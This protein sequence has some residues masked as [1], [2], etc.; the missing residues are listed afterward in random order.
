MSAEYASPPAWPGGAH[1]L[2][3]FC[4]AALA[5]LAAVPFLLGGYALHLAVSGGLMAVAAMALTVISGAAGL[6][7]L[8]TAAFLA[9]GAFTSGIMATQFGFGLGPSLFVSAA[10]G[11]F[12]GVLVAALTLRASGLYLA[13]G[14]LALQNVVHVVATD[15][16]LKLTFAAGFSL[17]DPDLLGLKI[18]TLAKWWTL[19]LVL[20]VLTYALFRHLL[21]SHVGREWSLLR[22]HPG[23]AAALGIFGAGSRVQVFALTSAVIAMAG[24][25][26]GYHIGNVQADTYTMQLAVIYLTVAALGG[27]G[28]LIG[29]IAASYLIIL[30]PGFIT[31]AMALLAVD[32]TSRAAG[33]ESVAIGIIL[34]F[35][36]LRGPQRIGAQLARLMDTHVPH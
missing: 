17:D 21:R 33:L 30:L 28:N 5:V 26:N 6:P 7:S 9:V 12:T 32:A 2:A 29:A 8:G 25:L 27:A 1:R 18:D 3:V 10:L 24:A 4:A 23:A 36:L 15:L 34:I 19:V 11:L 31:G 14:T 20:L 35:A 16:D 13:V 22:I